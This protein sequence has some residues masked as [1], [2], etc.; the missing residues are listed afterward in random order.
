MDL[1]R[2]EMELRI[3]HRHGDGSWGTFERRPSSHSPSEHDPE[4]DWINGVIYACTTCDEQI[5]VT[6]PVGDPLPD[7]PGLPRDPA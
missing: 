2:A 6:H 1:I 7:A 3:Q 4:R 5:R